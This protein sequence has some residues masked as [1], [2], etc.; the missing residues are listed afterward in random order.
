MV[1]FGRSIIDARQYLESLACPTIECL[2][3]PLNQMISDY[4]GKHFMVEIV[5]DYL[6]TP[7]IG[8]SHPKTPVG[9]RLVSYVFDQ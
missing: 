8:V 9:C 4:V 2:A 6:G 3:L 7:Y 5:V 1:D